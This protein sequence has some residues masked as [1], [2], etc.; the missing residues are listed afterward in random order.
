MRGQPLVGWRHVVVTKQ[1]TIVDFAQQLR[2][3]AD[4]AY[5]TAG[6]IRLVMDNL[7]TYRAASLYEAFPSEEAMRN[8]SPLEFHHTPNRGPPSTTLLCAS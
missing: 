2:W 4:E 7:N 5:S 1:R 8:A 6:T 3:L